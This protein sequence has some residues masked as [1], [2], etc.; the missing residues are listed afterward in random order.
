MGI[1][2]VFYDQYY[3]QAELDNVY[4][5]ISIGN[6]WANTITIRSIPF[7]SSS[8]EIK[9]TEQNG[10]IAVI[11]NGEKIGQLKAA[12]PLNISVTK[13]H[14]I[15]L[16]YDENVKRK[17]YY[18]IGNKKE[19][20]FS[21]TDDRADIVAVMIDSK[22][23]P[24]SFYLEKRD[25]LWKVIPEQ[26]DIPLYINGSKI[27]GMRTVEKGDV[28]FWNFQ[29][30]IILDED[31]LWTN[32]ADAVNVRLPFAAVPTS[33]TKRKYPEYRRTP[34]MIYELP[35]EKVSLSFPHS[36]QEGN[37]R[38]LFL[39]IL[40][41]LILLIVI[42]AIAI[43][44]PRGIFMIV[45]VVMFI[46]TIFTSTIQYFREKK[47]REENNEKRIRL[48]RAYLER[49]RAELQE[50]KEKQKFVLNYHFPSF[51]RMKYLT[52]NIDER[53]WERTLE[54]EDFLKVR[55]GKSDIPSS[56]K[57]EVGG[58]DAGN[59]EYDEL[60]EDMERLAEIY[61]TV[62]NVPLTIDV[63]YGSVGLIGKPSIVS[64]EIQQIVGQ[65][66]FFHSYHDVRIVAIF[67]EEEYKMWEWMKWLPHFQLPHMHAVGFIYNEQTRDQ[68]LTSLYEI[69]RE[70][71][72]DEDRKKKRFIPH[73]VFIVTNRSLISEHLILE[74]IEGDLENLSVSSIFAAPT[75]ENL[76][77]NIHTLVRY[78]NEQEGDILIQDKKANRIPF[79]LDYHE[80]HTNERLARTLASLEHQTGLSNSIP[81]KVTFMEMMNVKDVRELEIARNWRTNI[82][83]NSL[84]VPIG[85]KGKDD[86]VELNLHEK[87][88]GPHGLLAG[89]TGS[90]KSEFLQTYI[91]SL[92]VH[93]HPHDVAFLL[94]DYKGGGMAQPFKNLPH[95]LGTITNIEGSKNFSTRALTSIKSELKKRQRLFDKYGV[96]HIHKYSELYRQGKV[97]E[98]MPHLFLISDEFAE[99][100]QQEPEFISELVSA[101][102]IGRS[103]GVHLI[104][105]TQKPGG[106]VDNQIWSNTRFRI[107]LK[108]ADANDSKEI[109][110]N[111]D[112]A[113]IT[114]TGRGYLQV[115]NN[116]IYEL[117]QSAWSGAPYSID[118]TS[119]EDDVAI[120]TDLGLQKITGVSTTTEEKEQSEPKT[121]IEIVV[122]HI[123]EVADQ[124]N[125]Q[126]LASPWLPPLEE[127]IF[128]P[129]L[130]TVPENAIPLGIKDEPEKQSQAP[131]YYHL[132]DDGNIAIVGTSG[133]GKSYT[134]MTI[135]MSMAERWNP[136]EVQYYIFDFG[137]GALLPLRQLPHTGDYFRVDEIRK[138]EKFFVMIREEMER[139][140]QLFEEKEAS[141]IKMY[142]SLSEQKL[143]LIFIT[144]DNFDFVKDEFMDWENYFIQ[145]S[146]DGQS[147]GIF[148]ILTATRVNAMRLALTNNMKTRIVHYLLDEGEAFSLLGKTQ[149]ELEPVPGRAGVKKDDSYLAQIFLPEVGGDDIEVLENV[150]KKIALLKTEYAGY[151]LPPAIPMLPPKLDIEMFTERVKD[152][153]DQQ[154]FIPIGLD[155]ETV[156]PV[157]MDLKKNRHWLVTGLA[158]K[159]K[160]NVLKV[161]LHFVLQREP[162]QVGLFDGIDRG[163]ADFSANEQ[164]TYLDTKE[165]ILE[166]IDAAIVEFSAREEVYLEALKNKTVNQLDFYPIILMVDSLSRFQQTID[167]SLQQ[168]LTDLMK[169]YSHL[170]FSIIGAGNATEITKGFDS[171]T[172]ELK[173]IRNSILLMKKSEQNLY[174]FP[175]DRNEPEINPGFGYYV[176]NGIPRRIQIPEYTYSTIYSEV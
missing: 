165:Q 124:L 28:I 136:E 2:T 173:Q 99:L 127:R 150:R 30:F 155:E 71:E 17:Q 140:K 118:N 49:K 80:W 126:R 132:V 78:V 91:L 52:E 39:I 162:V 69:I 161:I 175:Y 56:Y 157:M 139:R 66:A 63:S 171:F 53:I 169:K 102:R 172:S 129:D 120:V 57:V 87:A 134:V 89:T 11:K 14:T 174:N 130:E 21:G 159:G 151:K 50:L 125:I 86:I 27:T 108:V 96:N 142:N 44:S 81:T 46:T 141:N 85:L 88:H 58:E 13:Y 152:V 73:F 9:K 156:V 20:Y 4:R 33:E 82:S 113:N 114:V 45:S 131:Y 144:V 54:S 119:A 176:V 79:F 15:T 51:E 3:Q 55:I 117:F 106:V 62:E 40:P 133:Y 47:T 1:I 128:Q 7:G 61:K 95:L 111:S 84:A 12:S 170:S 122:N 147:L 76:S 65:I 98:P 107:A 137:N 154:L 64:H 60:M 10:E 37:Q 70:R 110:K 38:G 48:Y 23:D 43:I 148:L 31:L 83:A 146:R 103:L 16:V 25:G 167:S 22:T 135:L 163:L 116:E 94:I 138:I 68:L 32:D 100:K 26:G 24:G 149:F 18:Y 6:D 97:T 67:H 34:R 121:E 123:A 36:P 160:T 19:L 5:P 90:G 72:L 164:V 105:A 75:K 115:G 35:D 153:P 109:L 8:I 143:P 29:E 101:A 168:Q 112:A 104:L 77:E 41:P 92:A 59:R 74:Y 42:G 93:F 145:F 158:Q 166:W